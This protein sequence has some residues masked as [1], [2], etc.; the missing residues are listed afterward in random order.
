MIPPPLLELRYVHAGYGP[1]ERLELAPL[2]RKE[3]VIRGVRSGR[4]EDL[5]SIIALA[6]AGRVRL[7]PIDTWPLGAIDDAIAAL[8]GRRVPGK[9]VI[10]VR[11]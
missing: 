3:L 9:A 2:A 4:R 7:P 6:A 1:I 11:S 10:D 8:R 5:E